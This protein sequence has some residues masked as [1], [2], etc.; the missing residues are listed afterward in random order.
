MKDAG[1]GD[2]N[3]CILRSTLQNISDKNGDD[4]GRSESA[5]PVYTE[6]DV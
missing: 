5:W 4:L 3:P 2:Q 1:A 6:K